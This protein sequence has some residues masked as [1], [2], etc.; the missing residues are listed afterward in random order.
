MIGANELT[1]DAAM[2]EADQRDDGRLR[3]SSS[4]GSLLS[5]GGRGPPVGPCLGSV[6]PWSLNR[7]CAELVITMLN[8]TEVVKHLDV[9]FVIGGV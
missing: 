2:E 6:S 5:R 8:V 3:H 7:R 4:E 1:G 9:T